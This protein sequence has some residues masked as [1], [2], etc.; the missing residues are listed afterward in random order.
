MPAPGIGRSGA[1][2]VVVVDELVVVA[3]SSK[4]MLASA[5]FVN[6]FEFGTPQELSK[7]NA[8][9]AMAP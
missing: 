9:D 2:V 6:S 5:I 4:G 7:I 8:T 1:K 3:L